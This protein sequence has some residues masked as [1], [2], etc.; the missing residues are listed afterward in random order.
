[1]LKVLYVSQNGQAECHGSAYPRWLAH[2]PNIEFMYAVSVLDDPDNPLQEPRDAYENADWQDFPEWFSGEIMVNN[3][4]QDQCIEWKHIEKKWL[5]NHKEPPDV[6]FV[7]ESAFTP[8][9]DKDVFDGVPVAFICLDTVKGVDNGLR[10]AKSIGADYIFQASEWQRSLWSMKRHRCGDKAGPGRLSG[11]PNSGVYFP[12]ER[13]FTMPAC[14]DPF[15]F[16]PPD[17]PTEK[18]L[19]VMW[20]GNEPWLKDDYSHIRREYKRLDCGY[21]VMSWAEEPER[22]CFEYKEYQQRSKLLWLMWRDPDINLHVVK[23]HYGHDYRKLMQA[24]KIV[25]HCQCGW[26]ATNASEACRIWQATASGAC[27]LTNE[28]DSIGTYFTPGEELETYRLYYEPNI[29]LFEWFDFQ[30]MKNKILDMLNDKAWRLG[31]GIAAAERTKKEHLPE[32]RF[33]FM[34]EKM[35]ICL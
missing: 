15:Y 30:E 35:G 11:A 33:R 5:K 29:H 20:V 17:K 18:P 6:I 4:Y 34:F 13:V 21:E 28:T 7:Y 14:A 23:P 22:F 26:N 24:S 32:H 16:H 3:G 2:H 27:L 12:P 31:L 25:W 9:G 8:C 1:M 19:D 10:I